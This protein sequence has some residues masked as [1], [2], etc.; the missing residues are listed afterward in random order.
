M[1][2]SCLGSIRYCLCNCL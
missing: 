1:L 2:M